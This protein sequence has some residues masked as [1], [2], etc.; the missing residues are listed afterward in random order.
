MCSL[1]SESILFVGIIMN[2][3]SNICVGK[4]QIVSDPLQ[5]LHIKDGGGGHN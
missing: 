5:T 2:R 3:N 1:L 4:W